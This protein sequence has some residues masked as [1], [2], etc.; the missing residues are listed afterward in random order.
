MR[1][2]LCL[3][4]KGIFRLKNNFSVNIRNKY[5]MVKRSNKKKIRPDFLLVVN[6]WQSEGRGIKRNPEVKS[7]P[8]RL[9]S[10]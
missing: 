9:T 7:Q 3:G 10:L 2:E 1:L 6:I 8:L 4:L 5:P